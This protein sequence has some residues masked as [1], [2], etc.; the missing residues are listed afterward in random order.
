L[1]LVWC[2]LAPI[3]VDSKTPPA[4]ALTPEQVE[5]VAAAFRQT[6]EPLFSQMLRERV[7]LFGRLAQATVW[8]SHHRLKPGRR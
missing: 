2:D 1:R 5:A 4:V 6:V 3:K 8:A 7:A